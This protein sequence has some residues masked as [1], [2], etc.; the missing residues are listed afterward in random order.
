MIE[1]HFFSVAL[2]CLLQYIS[3][4][5]LQTREFLQT[6]RSQ[7]IRSIETGSFSARLFHINVYHALCT[8]HTSSCDR[9]R[10]NELGNQSRSDSTKMQNAQQSA[11]S[12]SIPLGLELD[13]RHM[14][15]TRT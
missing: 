4:K 5:L 8:T 10:R 11:S 12:S 13:K 15:T 2:T 9:I 7:S 1:M 6:V 14:T 3:G